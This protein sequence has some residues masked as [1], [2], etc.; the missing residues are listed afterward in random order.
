MSR[1]EEMLRRLRADVEAANA[2]AHD[3]S[4][5]TSVPCSQC[6]EQALAELRI[7]ALPAAELVER[8]VQAQEAFEFLLDEGHGID[9]GVVDRA[10][11]ANNAVLNRCATALEVTDG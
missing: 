8:L 11:A 5:V 3:C 2:P 7:A 1:T 9:S 4:W 6:D 10:V